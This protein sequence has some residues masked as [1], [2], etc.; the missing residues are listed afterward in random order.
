MNSTDIT[1]QYYLSQ[2]GI[3]SWRER[4]QEQANVVLPDW[5]CLRKQVKTCQRC[6]LSQTRQNTVFGVGNTQADL[7]I[8]GEAP[9]AAEDKEGVPFVGRAGQLLDE[10]L[11]S[12]GLAR[13]SVFITNILKCHPPSNRDPHE[14]EV[15]TCIS[16]LE[17]QLATLQPKAILVV[18]RIAAHYLLETQE[19]MANLRGKQWRLSQ[20]G[21]PLFVTYHPDYVLRKPSEKRKVYLDLLAVKSYVT[22]PK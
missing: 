13:E 6:E 5:D 17:Q 7:V 2:M 12:I 20:M 11:L 18:G 21:I 10:M 15:T 9:G 3:M 19:P 22:M 1:Q 16:Y 14:Q 8:I 4:N